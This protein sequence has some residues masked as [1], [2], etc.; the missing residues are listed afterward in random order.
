MRYVFQ[1]DLL[2]KVRV[3]GDPVSYKSEYMYRFSYMNDYSFFHWSDCFHYI[4]VTK[5]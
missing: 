2:E 1:K 5:V 3:N 4:T